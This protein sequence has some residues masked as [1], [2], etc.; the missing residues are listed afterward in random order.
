MV[1]TV[2]KKYQVWLAGYYDDFNSARALPDDTNSPGSTRIHGNSHH[3]NPMN[4]EATLNP[5]YRWA[6]PDRDQTGSNLYAS[7]SNKFLQNDGIFEYIS[8]DDTRQS[9]NEWEGRAQLQYPDGHVANRYRFAGSGSLGYHKF[10]NGHDT[11]GTYL[12]PTGTNDA[13]FGRSDMNGYTSGLFEDSTGNQSNAGVK[14]T[15]GNFVQRAHLAGV[16]MGEQFLETSSNTPSTLFAEVHS[17]AKKPFLVVQSSRWDKTDNAAKPALIY[18]GPINTRL[19]GDTFTTRVAIRT[20]SGKG[21]TDWTKVGLQIEVGF[22]QPTSALTD[23]GFSGTPAIDQIIPLNYT[24]GGISGLTY[25]TKGELYNSSG[26]LQ[27]YTN[28]DTWLDIDLVFNYTDNNYDV[29]VNGTL[30]AS[31]IAMTDAGKDGTAD[32]ATTAANLYGYQI[33]VVNGE[34]GN[35]EGYVSYLMVDRAGLVRYLTNNLTGDIDDAPITRLK[36]NRSVNGISSCRV[37]VSDI[38]DLNTSDNVRGSS[39]ANYEHNLKDLFV[40]TSALDWNLLI[41]GDTDNRIDRPLWRGVV[42]KFN[43]SQRRRDRTLTFDARDSLSVM[44]RTLPLWEIGQEALNDS[45]D[46]TPYWLYEAKGFQ[47]VMNMGVRQLKLLGNDIGFDKDSGHIETSTQRTQLGSGHPIQMYNNEDSLYGPNNLENFYEG[48]GVTCIYKNASGHTVVE[49]ERN[50]GT[51]STGI[52]FINFTQSSHNTTGRTLSSQSSDGKTLT[53]DGSTSAKTITF[54]GEAAKIIY[55]GK[56]WGPFF[57]FQLYTNVQP[58]NQNWNF[59]DRL[60]P[61]SSYYGNFGTAGDLHFIFDADPGLVV[62]DEFAVNGVDESGTATVPSAY[63]GKHKVKQ[64]QTTKSYFTAQNGNKIFW[65][66]THTP[67]QIT[68]GGELGNYVTDSLLVGTSRVGFSKDKGNIDTVEELPY[69]AIHARW[70]RDMPDSLWFQYH[71]GVI[72]KDPVNNSN[73]AQQGISASQTIT[74]SS[75]KL[76]VTSTTYSNIPQYGVAEIWQW[77]GTGPVNTSNLEFRGKF[78][79][80]GKVTSGGNFFL[81]GCKYMPTFTV[82]IVS[83]YYIK[84]R[85]I[86]EDYKHIWLLWADMRNNG[87][88]D[89]DGGER[90][91]SFGVQHPVNENY[92][93]DMF[94]VDQT[95]ADGNIDKFASLKVD[96]DVRVWD[97][98]ATADPITNVPF[99]KPADYATP[100]AV[101]AI[102]SVGGKLRILTS[103]TTGV[104]AG[105]YVHL[106][107]TQDHDGGH[108]VDVVNAGTNIITTTAFVSS[109]LSVSGT[110]LYY[111]TTGSEEDLTIYKDWEDQAGAFLVV[112]SSPF[113]NL[114]TNSNNGKTGQE[115]GGVTDLVDYTTDGK[116]QPT[117]VDNYW[118]EATT[119]HITTGDKGLT[120]P[121]AKYIISDVTF[122]SDLDNNQTYLNPNYLGL[123]VNDASI[124][125][126]NGYGQMRAKILNE[127][128]PQDFYFEWTGKIETQLGPFTVA[129]ASTATGAF[130]DLT[131]QLIEVSGATFAASGV[132]EGMVL[133]RTD[134]GDS[135][136]HIHNI[137]NVGDVSD[138]NT[139]TKLVVQGSTF[140]ATDTFVIPIQLGKIYMTELTENEINLALA[141]R[142]GFE[143]AIAEK[144]NA[145]QGSTWSIFGLKAPR[146]DTKAVEVHPTIGSAFMLRLMMH[147]DGFIKSRN[148]GTFFDSDKIRTLWNAAIIDSW[149][150]PTRLTAMQDI[151]NVPNTTIMTTYND[152]TSNDSYGSMLDTRNKTLASILSSMR[153]KSGI[154]DTNGIKTTFSYLIGHDNRLE[155]RPNYNSHLSFTRQNMKI[156]NFSSVTTSQITNVRVYYNGGAS[157]VDHPKPALTDTTR[158]RILEH[159][160]VKSG[161]EALFLAKQEFNKN[162]NAPM[163]LSI[164]PILESDV[165]YKMI[166]KGRYGYIADPYIALKGRNA[167]DPAEYKYV[168]NWTRLGSGGVLFPGMVSG[169]DGNQ[170]TTTDIYAR[171]GN[172]AVDNGEATI[173]YNENYTWYG[174]NSI[175]Y[176]LQIVDATNGLPFVSATSGQPLRIYVDLKSGQS[177]T[178]IDNAEFTIHLKDYS[179]ANNVRTSTTEGS[180][181]IDVKHSGFYKIDVPNSY[182]SSAGGKLIISFNAEYC[183]ALLRHR[184]GDPT[185]ANILKQKATNTNTIFPIGKREYDFQGGTMDDRCEW[186]A[187]RVHI[188]R[189]MSYHPATVISVTDPGLGLSSATDMVIQ[190]IG[191][192]VM[193]GKTD[194]V[195]LKLERDES[196]K[197]GSLTTFLFNPNGAGAQMGNDWGQNLNPPIIGSDAQSSLPPVNLPSVDGTPTLISGGSS[198]T[199]TGF[200]QNSLSINQSSRG[201]FG[202]YRGRMNFN[203]LGNSKLSVLGQNRI[204]VTPTAMLG[205]EGGEGSIIASGGSAALTADGYVFGGKGLVGTPDSTSSSQRISLQTQFVTPENVVNDDIHVT[206]KVSCGTVI[207]AQTA[208][209]ET[210]VTNTETGATVT[211]TATISTNTQRKTIDLISTTKLAGIST[212]KTRLEVVVVRKPGTGSDNANTQ[213]VTLHNLDVRMNRAATATASKSSQFSTFS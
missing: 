85:S 130:D 198:D 53:F 196:I 202:R 90:K 155:F 137:I 17:P 178:D 80:Q 127:D 2:D 108:I 175:S 147:M 44:D 95:D 79:Y 123:P 197:P 164:E 101:T 31:N 69:R 103:T 71:F 3:G 141:S 51:L 157:F 75:N 49:L 12:V 94:Y 177:G 193:A 133:V 55:M 107:G 203:D 48:L 8:Y 153:Q 77:N 7:S 22:A 81:I 37:E 145:E 30:K 36:M 120:H 210:T 23:T 170:A 15:T 86:Q 125:T 184:C 205:I 102:N 56:A 168:T 40:A 70:M 134:A 91:K 151:N 21:G 199:Q 50:P 176:A 126:E 190:D 188:C 114:N 160:N 180:A 162:Q 76:Q 131:T 171:F 32:S 143:D 39:T 46:E 13:T 116:G 24:A 206:A 207:T 96:E 154:G 10:V 159:P 167:D 65:V 148:S 119:S 59:Q 47:D 1:R 28:D 165:D 194:S 83:T 19:D 14:D 152:T 62:G 179:F 172:S 124:F 139:D 192:T 136:Q 146:S 4:G 173:A 209:L 118:A 27:S 26:V 61:N 132:K 9:N 92:E 58:F 89:A 98:D 135:T 174:A 68:N 41:F 73:L 128:I 57:D 212:P 87:K 104:V 191:W 67:Y 195:T 16:W 149:L 78:V 106:V 88:A 5:R 201:S 150:P 117:L 72:D 204:G 161:E 140:A 200:G 99:S 142:T 60:H 18:D 208:V 74:S 100:R 122:V 52:G 156:A 110:A 182:D 20:M 185:S 183:R 138:Q 25:D 181:N 189:D 43:I 113:F 33:T 84:V 93:I 111:P 129:S 29:Y 63:I 11:L 121:N 169:L 109:T 213:S 187:P 64:I 115:A 66:K 38:P 112:D 54:T 45:E 166:E 42:E 163:S 97:L 186:Y 144:F 82:G 211:G 6:E 34:S 158:W 105:D 35:Q